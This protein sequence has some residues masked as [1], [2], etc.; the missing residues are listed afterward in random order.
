[1]S[2]LSE[3]VLAASDYFRIET[4]RAERDQRHYPNE[5][6]IMTVKPWKSHT[7]DIDTLTDRD[8]SVA[9]VTLYPEGTYGDAYTVT[10]TAKRKPGD[11]PNASRGEQLAIARALLKLGKD[12][13]RAAT[14]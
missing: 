11:K 9:A 8:A 10:G 4:M 2:K 14:S 13:E 7:I 5:E 12:L 6:T 3:Q 1:M